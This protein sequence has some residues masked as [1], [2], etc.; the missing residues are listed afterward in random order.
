MKA[1]VISSSNQTSLKRI[2]EFIKYFWPKVSVHENI[3]TEI[4]TQKGNFHSDSE[5]REIA[6][7]W[8][9]RKIGQDELR[10]K[11]WRIS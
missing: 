10:N 7:I 5:F 1:I 3:K 9:E 11:S 8:K 2:I 4:K 6:G